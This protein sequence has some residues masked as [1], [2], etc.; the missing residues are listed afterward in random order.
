[1]TLSIRTYAQADEARV[2]HLRTRGGEHEIDLILERGDGCIVAM[3]EAG[4][5][6]IELR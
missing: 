5:R 4:D 6:L 3:V 2:S 1:V